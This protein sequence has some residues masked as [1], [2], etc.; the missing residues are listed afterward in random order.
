MRLRMRSWSIGLAAA[1]ILYV[2]TM[3]P[4][5]LWGDGGEAQLHVLSSEWYVHGEI[6][7]S[8]VLFYAL[9]RFLRIMFGLEPTRA[10]NLLAAFGGALT[11]A[12]VAWLLAALCRNAAAILGGTVLLLVS[13]TLWQM[14]ASADCITLSTALLTTELIGLIKLMETGRWRWLAAI[15]LLN[16]L[17]ISN[18]DLA[19]LMWPVYLAAAI[20][21]WPRWRQQRVSAIVTA[22]LGVLLGAVPVLLLCVDDW[23]RRG[24]LSATAES[25]LFGQYVARVANV[26]GVPK[27]LAR[28]L[29]IT[30]L[31]FPT[32]LLACCV[33]GLGACRRVFDPAIAWALIGGM[34]VYAVFGAR[35]DV[36]DQH[37]FLVPAF[38]FLALF[39]ALGV[40]QWIQARSQSDGDADRTSEERRAKRKDDASDQAIRSPILG[41][42]SSGLRVRY[43]VVILFLSMLGPI[44][45]AAAPPLL[46]R[47]ALEASFLPS[48]QVAHRDPLKWFLRPWRA[49]YDGPERFARKTLQAL[50]HGAWLA[51]DATLCTPLNY[52][53]AAE[54]FRRDVRLDSWL[55]R[56][57]W[58]DDGD[59]QTLREEKLA[60][61]LLFAA[62]RDPHYLPAWLR[63]PG[64]RFEPIGH[65]F[66]VSR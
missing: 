55:A 1:L 52:L 51:V 21:F 57:P 25:F 31:N 49:G 46:R 22:G 60:A 43:T 42:R 34:L 40:D 16:G 14:S 26:G 62:S 29:G 23:W 64:Y 44:V 33:T 11:V 35:Y 27:L 12:N 20:R 28:T 38:V 32:P 65:V 56:Q 47:F 59:H 10:A 45:Y 2:A 30:L 4:G 18:H 61:G 36:P 53:Q 63:Q 5:L 3:A 50:P 37:T 8:H 48:R 58:F 24:D 13:H 41:V 6:A 66:R 9:A 39:I 7:R 17:G 54:S 19:L 15:A